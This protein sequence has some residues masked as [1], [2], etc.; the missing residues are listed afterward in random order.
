[1]IRFYLDE[2]IPL[3]VASQ[4]RLR[5]LEITCAKEVGLLGVTDPVHFEHCLSEGRVMVT[6][7]HGDYI[8][9]TSSRAVEHLPHFGLVF[10]SGAVAQGDIGTML[11]LLGSLARE[12]PDGLQPYSVVWLS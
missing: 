7:D 2:H 6:H 12:H 1:M 9:L 3:A 11:R 5:G 8:A 10:F 4:G